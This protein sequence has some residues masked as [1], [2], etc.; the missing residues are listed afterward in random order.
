MRSINGIPIYEL[1]LIAH[2]V[3]FTILFLGLM[4]AVGF[5]VY[6]SLT[7]KSPKARERLHKLR[8]K[9]QNDELAKKQLEKIK[10]KNKRRRKREKES[11]ITDIIIG[12]L[13]VCFTIVL[14]A[15][16][17]IPGWMDYGKKDYVVYTGEI[18]VHHQ[19]KR[20]RIELDDGTVIWGIGD[21]DEEDTYGTVVYS[22]R[23]KLFL[24][25]SN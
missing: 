16:G 5:W 1:R 4:V 23:T 13:S 24:G 8:K 3:I 12:S 9:A 21:F 18:T 15:W 22:R 25:G 10:R 6:T 7:M 19:M 17:V 2:S 14:L 11:I 20:S